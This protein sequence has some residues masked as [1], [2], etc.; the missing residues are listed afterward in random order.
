MS[1]LRSVSIGVEPATGRGA[2]REQKSEVAAR[3]AAAGDRPE[4]VGAA[5]RALLDYVST[6][7]L[8]ARLAFFELPSAGPVALDRADE[9]LGTFIAYLRPPLAPSAIGGPVSEVVYEAI[10]TG[11]WAVLQYE[12]SHG[13]REQ[14]AAVGPE[15]CAVALAP[16]A[17]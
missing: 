12:I 15:L 14:I 5:L 13:R 6:H 2:W 17:V 9:M 3:F 11:S 1:R 10:G 16:F 8:F 4:A 7:E